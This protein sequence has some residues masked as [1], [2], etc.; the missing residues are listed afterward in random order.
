MKKRSDYITITI[1]DGMAKSVVQVKRY[2]GER[3]GMIASSVGRA[4]SEYL[5]VC[6][7]NTQNNL[8]VK[9]RKVDVRVT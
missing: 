8:D 6:D 5:Y 4:L 1:T 2:N 7:A 3:V 9:M